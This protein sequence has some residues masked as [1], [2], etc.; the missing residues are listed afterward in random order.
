MDA[1]E[2]ECRKSGYD[3]QVVTIDASLSSAALKELIGKPA[4]NGH[5]FPRYRVDSQRYGSLPPPWKMPLLVVD[6][7]L[8]CLP[9]S[10]VTIG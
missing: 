5:H 10:S 4:I 8:S 2:Q 6:N 9:V 7:S 3:L 1:V